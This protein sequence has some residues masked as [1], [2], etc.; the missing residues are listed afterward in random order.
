MFERGISQGG[1]V[2]SMP[3]KAFMGAY[4]YMNEGS[5]LREGTFIGR[6]CSIGRRVTIGAGMHAMNGVSTHPALGKGAGP[7]Y[8]PEQFEQLGIPPRRA[9]TE[10]IVG[11]DVW[12]GDGAVI[13]PGVTIGAGAVIGANSVVT[14]DV[15]PY[16][17]IGGIP[18]KTIR[19]RHPPGIAERLLKSEYWELPLQLLKGMPT[20]NVFAFLDALESLSWQGSLGFETFRLQAN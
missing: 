19:Q 6:Y 20:N 2:I 4:S 5:L 10:T 12:I 14:R 18:A 17:V 3:G 15:P 16:T 8:T 9:R 7:K 13:M 11:T 1:Q